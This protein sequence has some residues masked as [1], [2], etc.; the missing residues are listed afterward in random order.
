[1]A[2]DTLMLE[3]RQLRELVAAA[4][5]DIQHLHRRLHGRDDRRIAG[6]LWPLLDDLTEGAPF[7]GPA[8]YARAVQ[9]RHVPVGAAACQ[10]IVEHGADDGGLRSFGKFLARLEGVPLGE[11]RL[12]R[13]GDSRA[14]VVW[15]LQ[16]VCVP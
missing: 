14:G 15:Q 11:L 9:Q 7:T 6:A 5:D 4:L 2:P 13:I 3:V 1:M 8:A 16:R 12:V 10:L